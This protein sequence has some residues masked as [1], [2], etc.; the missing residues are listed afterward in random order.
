MYNNGSLTTSYQGSAPSIS[1]AANTKDSLGVTTKGSNLNIAVGDNISVAVTET[2]STATNIAYDTGV[3][4]A[5]GPGTISIYSYPGV[6][7]YNSNNFVGVSNLMLDPLALTQ[8]VLITNQTN[9]TAALTG[10]YSVKA[11]TGTNS[12]T[13]TDSSLLSW[14]NATGGTINPSYTTDVLMTHQNPSWVWSDATGGATQ[15]YFAGYAK[16]PSGQSNNGCIYKST[17]LGSSTTTATGVAAV[18]NTSVFQPF[19]LN[20]PT[21][22]LPM[23]PDE[24]P[25]CIQSYLN[26]VFVGTNR[27]IRM[28]QTLSVYDPSST[29]TGDL[30]AGAIIPNMLPTNI[31]GTNTPAINYPVTAIVGDGRFVWFSWNKYDDYSTG[32]GKLDLTNFINGDALTPAYASDIMVGPIGVTYNTATG[33]GMINGLIWDPAR[34]LPAMAIGGVGIYTAEATNTT[35]LW[36]VS[37]FVSN[38]TIN[39]PLFDYGLPEEK[40]ALSF[41]IGMATPSNGGGIIAYVNNNPDMPAYSGVFSNSSLTVTNVTHIDKLSVGML[42]IDVNN[43][44]TLPQLAYITSINVS[45]QTITVSVLPP[46]SGS[47]TFGAYA[48]VPATITSPSSMVAVNGLSET[49]IAPTRGNEF[50]VKVLIYPDGTRTQSPV[51]HRW[52][53]KSWPTVVQG[54]DIMAVFQL[55]S[56]AVV[57]GSETYVDPYDNFTWLENLRQKQSVVTYQEGPLSVSAIVLSIDWLPHKR[58]D[59][60]ENGFEGDC[61]VTFKTVDKYKYTPVVTS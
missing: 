59:N 8:R 54:T 13:V 9:V 36:N 10:T 32:L 35:G 6:V 3:V 57:D 55:F 22:A 18:S 47:M 30:K 16:N 48:T 31:A 12:F 49:S 28:A 38:G 56:V 39:S 29:S 44:G 53:L 33:Q 25:T 46:V 34:N 58:R 52:T 42:L 43:L 19:S 45:A 50:Q 26:F 61:V 21:Q 14:Q 20:Y 24:Y 5:V 4:T 15:I 2:T 37:K 11:V 23:S 17:L 40:V 27:G 1:F 41:D 7:T 60:Y 51:L